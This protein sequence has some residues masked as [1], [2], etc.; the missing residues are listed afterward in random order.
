MSEQERT[1]RSRAGRPAPTGS[2]QREKDT[3]RLP[4]GRGRGR[5]GATRLATVDVAGGSTSQTGPSQIM[6]PPQYQHEQ[7]YQEQAY[8]VQAYQ[9]GLNF[10]RIISIRRGMSITRG[11]RLSLTRDISMSSLLSNSI[12]SLLCSSSMSTLLSSSCMSS[13]LSSSI[14]SSILNTM[15]RLVWRMRTGAFQGALRLVSFTELR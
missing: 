14:L 15:Q 11:I 2:L 6:D 9:E 10:S 12:S 5:A 8:E 4:P 7:H 1:G 3:L 13:I